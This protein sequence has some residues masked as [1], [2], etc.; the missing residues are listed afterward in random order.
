LVVAGL[1]SATPAAANPNPIDW[2]VYD[3]YTFSFGIPIPL[4]YG[5]HDHGDEDGFGKHHIEDG[6]GVGSRRRS[7]AAR[8][9]SCRSTRSA[10][11]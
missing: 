3:M 4:R 2:R 10:R 8:R 7:R 9:E 6:R 5:Q 11:R 1:A